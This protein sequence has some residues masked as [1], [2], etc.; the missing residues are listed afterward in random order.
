MDADSTPSA[1]SKKKGQRIQAHDS[2]AVERRESLP[3]AEVDE[4]TRKVL[5]E[6]MKHHFLFSGVKSSEY[7]QI[8]SALKE[9]RL[10]QGNVVFRQGDAGDCCYFIRFGR[11]EVSIDGRPVKELGVAET[12]GE[13]ALLYQMQR[14]ATITCVSQTALI[15]TMA[16]NRFR[17]CMDN[18]SSKQMERANAF[19]RSDLNFRGLTS[20][21]QGK[22]AAECSVQEFGDGDEIL[23]AGEEGNWMFI[24]ISGRVRHTDTK[25]NFDRTGCVLGSIGL[26]YGK[27]QATGAKANGRVACLALGKTALERLPAP[28][29]DVLR[30]AAFK[31]LLQGAHRCD[32]QRDCIGTMSEEQLHRMIG[33]A[34]DGFFEPGEVVCAPGDP[35]QLLIVVDGEVAILESVDRIEERDELAFCTEPAGA[36]ALRRRAEKVLNDGMG[37][38][39]MELCFFQPMSRY[40]LAV[41]NVRLHRIASE[42]VMEAFG[43]PLFELARRN[44]IKTV[45]SDIFL[46]KNLHEEQIDRTVKRME[47]H[48]FNAGEVV[49]KQDDPAQHFYL[50]Q[51]GTVCVKRNEAVIRTLGRW[52]YF[53]ERGLLNE[54]RRSATCQAM[55]ECVCLRLDKD[56]FFEIVGMFRKELERRMQLQDLNITMADLRIRAIVGRGTFGVVRLVCHSGNEQIQYALK[57]VKKLHVVRNNQEKSIVME[58]EVNAQCF[59]PCIVQFI[60]TFQDHD[61]VYFLTEFL[62]GGDLFQAI[63]QIGV[64]SKPQSQFFSGSIVLALEYLH[65]RGIMYRDLKPENVLLDFAGQTKLVDFGCCKKEQSTS[66]L[67]GTPEYLAPE[68][69]QGKGYTCCVDWWSLG[70]MM[71]EFIVGPLPFGA[72]TDDQMA[73]FREILE[74]PLRIPDYVKDPEAVRVL[75]ALL[76]R[77]ATKRLGGSEAGAREIKEHSYYEGFNWH[78]LAGGFL[79]PPWKPPVAELRKSWEPPDGDLMSHVKSSSGKEMKGMEWARGF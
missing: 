34:E 61:H 64:V 3:G 70:V 76:V 45:L 24:V 31:T 35:A 41:G 23:R 47:Q 25:A 57:A 20:E 77:T 30:R 15:Y 48:H 19:F 12:F 7:S 9:L 59:H 69:I 73:L 50:I 42:A 49:V 67:L 37:H 5:K 54:E 13:L 32:G 72:D 75:K 39:E 33:R 28:V 17:Q 10:E 68:V 65:A 1:R 29:E 58:R 66:T 11:F 16:G 22:L 46:F 26:L 55:E 63:R 71:Y 2:S 53:G 51:S 52:D 40:A 60:K 14:S 74:A 6:I 27:R 44:E 8:F 36:D 79:E 38:G 78:A 21:D 56:V 62:G 43:E 4:E 18:L